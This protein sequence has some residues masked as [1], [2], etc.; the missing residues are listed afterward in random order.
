MQT[1]ETIKIYYDRNFCFYVEK[2]R[3][4]KKTL[5]SYISM[6]QTEK[7]ILAT[8]YPDEDNTIMNKPDTEN[9]DKIIEGLIEEYNKDCKSENITRLYK[10]SKEYKFIHIDTSLKPPCGLHNSEYNGS[11]DG[12]E[13]IAFIKALEKDLKKEHYG[14]FICPTCNEVSYQLINK[15]R[16]SCCGEQFDSED[17]VA[18]FTSD[19]SAS[20][21]TLAVAR[22]LEEKKKRRDQV[23]DARIEGLYP[24]TYQGIVYRF[25]YPECESLHKALYDNFAC[26]VVF[27]LKDDGTIDFTDKYLRYLNSLNV[28]NILED[29]FKAVGSIRKIINSREYSIRT[30]E[31]AFYWYINNYGFNKEHG[32]VLKVDNQVYKFATIDEYARTFVNSKKEIM[33]QL[34]KLF[35]NLTSQ[36]NNIFDGY[37]SNIESELSRLVYEKTKEYVFISDSDIVKFGKR[38]IQNLHEHDELIYSRNLFMESIRLNDKFWTQIKNCFDDFE[39]PFISHDENCY[40]RLCFYQF[41]ITGKKVLKYKT[42]VI[43]NSKNGLE[44]I[45]SII[46]KSYLNPSSSQFKELVELVNNQSL[47]ER[48]DKISAVEQTITFGERSRESI[49]FDSL[50]KQLTGK[51]SIEFYLMCSDLTEDGHKK[52]KIRFGDDG[53]HTFSGQLWKILMNKRGKSLIDTINRFYNDPDIKTFIDL[54]LKRKISGGSEE[55]NRVHDKEFEMLKASISEY[56][57]VY[58]ENLTK[59]INS[60]ITG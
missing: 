8:A 50:R 41:A 57:K 30:V 47:C 56:T 39:S 37:D 25:S 4:V 22:Y 1:N 3:E 19:D 24:L 58:E 46:R 6:T 15:K 16:V 54:V 17:C 31:R 45:K 9:A 53:K 36:K 59:T 28:N 44:Q 49:T 51:V 40:D 29:L 23:V 35:N 34:K 55:F 5:P 48:L 11:T 18:I 7:V 20:N 21:R 42:L 60:A 10:I 26:E 27:E 33:L 2:I 12:D 38:F 13:I 52:I 14:V 32:L 43:D